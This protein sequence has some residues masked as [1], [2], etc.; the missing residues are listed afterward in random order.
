MSDRREV[1]FWE[2]WDGLWA[3]LHAPQDP[4][5]PA[6][7]RI[8]FGALLFARFLAYAP[9]ALIQ[10]GPDGFLP[11]EF[12][13]AA[14]LPGSPSIFWILPDSNAVV[15]TL[16]AL[17]TAQAFLLMIG[18]RSRFQ[19]ALLWFW[20]L[21]FWS[22]GMAFSDAGDQATRI[23]LFLLI[24]MPLGARWSLDAWLGAA[25]DPRMSGLGLRLF[26]LKVVIV[27]LV[28]GYYKTLGDTWWDGTAMWHVWMMPGYAHNLP[29]P[30]GLY[31]NL[32][33]SRVLSWLTLV[34]EM[35]LPVA[36]WFR[37]S[38]AVSIAIAVLFHFGLIYL[39]NIF[40]FQAA[41][42]IGW[43]A[44]LEPTADL[45]MAEDGAEDLISESPTSAG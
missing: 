12:A 21:S 27:F 28:A 29:V 19:A 42:V 36:V 13:K 34:L 8:L 43:L 24:F 40:W 45:G 17:A 41:M 23:L 38:R 2:L 44:F 11:L 3:R 9:N 31:T 6:A 30:D 25:D 39:M 7:L 33:T 10:Y 20:F 1:S 14:A 16:W 26:R 37:R 15:I 18:W 35:L 4:R 32:W 22:R 5:I